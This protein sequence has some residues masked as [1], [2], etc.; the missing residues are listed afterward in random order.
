VLVRRVALAPP[1]RRE[2]RWL[3]GWLRRVETYR[4]AGG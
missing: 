1:E 4:T 3:D 2:T